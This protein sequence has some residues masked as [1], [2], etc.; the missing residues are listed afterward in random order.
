MCM[1]GA[2]KDPNSGIYKIDL[3]TNVLKKC[4]QEF[5]ASIYFHEAIHVYLKVHVDEW[6]DRTLS[7]HRVMLEEYFN[8]M[9]KSVVD[10]FPT[11]SLRDAYCMILDCITNSDDDT[12]F[13]QAMFDV[14][15]NTI[16]NLITRK[17]PEIQS[18]SDIQDIADKYRE[19]GTAGTRNSNCN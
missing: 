18:E 1:E 16:I 15:K 4:S 6:M 7:E 9:S 12:N 10:I 14:M 8:D 3:N 2:Y 13:D 5:I 17:F 19:T 11:L